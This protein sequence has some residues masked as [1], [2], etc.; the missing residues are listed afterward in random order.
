[1]VP[2]PVTPVAGASPEIA[3]FTRRLAASAACALPLVVLA[4]GPVL[5]MA[6]LPWGNWVQFGLASPVVLWAAQPFFRRGRASIK[7]RSANM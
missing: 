3:D 6:A 5:G 4:L 2:E 7:N 1:M